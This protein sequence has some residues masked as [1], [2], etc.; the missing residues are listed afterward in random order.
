MIRD[1]VDV[2]NALGGYHAPRERSNCTGGRFTTGR[3][4]NAEYLRTRGI[5]LQ[6]FLGL[7]KPG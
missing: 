5:T 3:G 6:P 7:K 4:P 2:V 1:S